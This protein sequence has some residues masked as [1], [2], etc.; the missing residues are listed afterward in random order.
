M[1]MPFPLNHARRRPHR[2]M[3]RHL[4]RGRRCGR[5]HGAVILEAEDVLM[6]IPTGARED[7]YSA[8][9]TRVPLYSLYSYSLSSRGA[10]NT[11]HTTVF[12]RP[13]VGVFS[14]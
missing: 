10:L 13:H 5:N 12:P 9:L 1:F 11:L 6:H 14:T 3:L 4:V 8:V 2:G 7:T